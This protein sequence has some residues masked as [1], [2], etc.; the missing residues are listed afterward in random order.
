MTISETPGEMVRKMAGRQQ[1]HILTD[2]ES[3]LI[4]AFLNALNG[5]VPADDIAMPELPADGPQLPK[6]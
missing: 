1:G 6:P 5:K 3:G 2:K 4:S